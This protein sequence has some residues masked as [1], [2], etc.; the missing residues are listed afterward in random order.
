[1]N[2]GKINESSDA[3]NESV[4]VWLMINYLGAQTWAAC[5]MS[6]VSWVFASL[7]GAAN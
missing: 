2:W 5:S 7:L 3:E 4:V 6:S 1:M